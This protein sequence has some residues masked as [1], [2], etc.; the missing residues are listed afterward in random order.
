MSKAS[1]SLAAVAIVLTAVGGGRVAAYNLFGPYPWGD[2]ATYYNKWGDIFTPGSTG[3]TITWSIMPDGT[4]IDPSWSDPNI[5][6][7]SSLEAIMTGLGHAQA[8]ATIERVLDKWSAVANIYFVQVPDSGAPFSSTA[9]QS[10][11]T[12]Q[13]RFGA[14]SIAGFVG[15]VGF[16]PPPNGGSLEGDV[17]LNA[18]NT[19]FFD[20]GGEGDPI[21]IFNDFESLL[22]HEAGHALGMAHSDVC[23]VMSIEFECFQYVN[24]EL[25]PDDIAG[26]QFLYGA[27]LAADFDRDNATTG[28]DLGIWS[29]NFGAAGGAAKSTGDATGDGA[30]DGRDFLV[31]QREFVVTPIA[32]VV[33][34]PAAATLAA[35]ALT[36][37]AVGAARFSQAA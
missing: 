4:T 25:D 2:E 8:L 13:I 11:D 34:E 18:D 16:A 27:A 15:G 32:T 6:G 9:A 17:L 24:R 29:A 22:L 36:A 12:G 3:G 10:P 33:P 35:L 26:I 30:V 37:I 20:P 5:T 14:F 19:F 28:D 23:S 7:T 31:W 1:C 21:Q